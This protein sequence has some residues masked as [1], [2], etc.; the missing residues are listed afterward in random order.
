MIAMTAL[1]FL[2]LVPGASASVMGAFNLANCGGGGVTVYGP[3]GNGANANLIDF[4]TPMFGG[5][6]C[7]VTGG[8][9][10][11]TYFN[12]VSTVALGTNTAGTVN[13]LSPGTGA[14]GFFAFPTAPT[15]VFNLTAL[16][17][18]VANL[19]CAGL[20]IG[21]SCSPFA[22]SP[23][24]FTATA[25][26]TTLELDATGNVHDAGAGSNI[27]SGAFTVQLPGVS[28]AAL[29][30]Q[31]LAAGGTIT[32]TWSGSFT[33]SSPEP[34]TS[35]MIGGGLLALGVAVRRRKLTV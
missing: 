26:G 3:N 21:Q 33:S 29:Q 9:T 10:T 24:I 27:W 4:L 12:G 11:L 32:S 15:L 18:G 30:N 14:A 31:L 25:T 20:S 6:G 16:G 23:F 7:D 28:A 35:L 34:L 17:P 1:V 22:S 13:D 5:N 8:G 19:V 2:T